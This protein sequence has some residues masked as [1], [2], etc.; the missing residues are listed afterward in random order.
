M[1]PACDTIRNPFIGSACGEH[2]RVLLSKLST[3]TPL[4][5]L[6][7]VAKE[8]PFMADAGVSIQYEARTAADCDIRA[9]R[10]AS[11]DSVDEMLASLKKAPQ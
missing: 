2:G 1:T 10:L 3:F 8:W 9:G 5:A 11:F 7:I 4:R 6:H